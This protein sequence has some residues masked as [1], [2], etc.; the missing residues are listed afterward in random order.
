M[1]A[2]SLTAITLLAFALPY[3]AADA[4]GSISVRT[5]A[6]RAESLVRLGITFDGESNAPGEP[7]AGRIL[8]E[9]AGG[10]H[11][12]SVEP[13][14]DFAIPTRLEIDAPAVR[15]ESTE[16]PPH[17]ERPFDF[18]G[19]ETL[20]VYEGTL[21]VPFRGVRIA[22]DDERFMVSV[23]YQAC[24]D[25][26]CLPPRT[27]TLETRLGENRPVGAAGEEPAAP[28]PP[29]GGEFTRLEDAPAGGAGGGLFSADLGATFASRG[30]LLTLVVVFVLGLALN[31]TPCVYPLIPITVGY[32]ASQN[33]RGRAARVG[34][35]VS[36]VLGIA[37]TY[38]ILGV[39]SALSGRLFGAWLQ[40]SAVL[41]FF[42]ILMLVLAAS[43]FGAFDIRVPQFIASRSGAKA[44]Y[45][46]ALTM[47]LLAGIVAAPCVG[48][49]VIS[50]IALVA[51]SQ[52]IGLG[53]ILFFVLALGL[54]V[55][56]L[57]LG[58]F[59]SAVNAI[60]R[61]GMWLVQVKNAFGFILVAM[62]FYFL[63]PLVGEEIYRWGVAA[64]L[65]V[66]A[67]FLFLGGRGVPA[68]RVVRL[69]AAII[70]LAG[71]IVFALPKRVGPEV[72]WRPYDSAILDQASAQGRPVMIDFYADWCLPCKELDNRT[73]NDP[74]VVAE[75]ERFVRLKAD[76]TRPEDP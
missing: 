40:S 48:P 26:I 69:S 75:S 5:A 42:A 16:F 4:A 7:V 41:V 44:G 67:A 27:V 68:G 33:E 72:Q 8:V 70:L 43:M 21:E 53:F 6:P 39:T 62:A 36:Y 61:S 9:I 34:L 47:G 22:E 64:S 25:S 2:A 52:S 63:R 14:S 38:S 30:L 3:S 51:Q 32:F 28:A 56:Y 12:N 24:D 58:I 15:I 54:G 45:A 31:L 19:G 71:G 57:L 46:G 20:A 73:F 17:I 29:A 55:P 50:L 60:P 18:A 11:I 23:F 74:A 10:W 59:S 49:F 76:L 13:S 1:R 66:G 37:A 35:S 65:L